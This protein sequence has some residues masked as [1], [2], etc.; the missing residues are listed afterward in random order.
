[1]AA[2]NKDLRANVIISSIKIC[3]GADTTEPELSPDRKNTIIRYLDSANKY[4]PLAIGVFSQPHH[5]LCPIICDVYGFFGKSTVTVSG[6]YFRLDASNTD[7][8]NYQ[9]QIVGYGFD[10]YYNVVFSKTL[11]ASLSNYANC[12]LAWAIE[13][14]NRIAYVIGIDANGIPDLNNGF[15]KLDTTSFNK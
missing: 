12:K 1:M 8:M 5:D 9:R 2:I 15:Y 13:N 7:T 11:L 10:K 14:G 4:I 3:D 6:N